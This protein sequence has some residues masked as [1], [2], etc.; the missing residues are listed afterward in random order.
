MRAAGIILPLLALSAISVDAAAIDRKACIAAA[1]D[2]QKLRDDGKLS[3]AR[4][5]FIS[6]AD[7]ACPSAVAKQ[8]ADWVGEVEHDT[9][10]IS[11]RAKD[12]SGKEIF[13]VEVR[14]D[15][16]SVASSIQPKAIAVDPG[17][18]K[19]KFV[20]KDGN[21]IEDTFLLRN[22]EKDRIIELT[23]MPRAPL[24]PVA[25]PPAA[26][27]GAG[28]QIPWIAWVGVGVMVLGG[29]GTAAFA[30]SANADESDLRSTC[31]PRCDPADRSGIDTKLVLANVSLG[32][33]FAGLGLAVVSTIVAN[34]THKEAPTT[35][36]L[37]APL[38]NG[39]A[40]GW[41][42]RF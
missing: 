12:P 16:K 8:C 7:K 39:A 42:G 37:V 24:I 17:T 19:I 23:F 26:G 1:D 15:D 13:D 2:G 10:T 6:C 28:F 40:L 22:A 31:A 27:G 14:I 20:L 30:V 11:F 3:E 35:G 4:E 34:V 29:V 9:P 38:P 25:P 5:K 33:A 36:L 21:T 32:L 41:Q 18:H